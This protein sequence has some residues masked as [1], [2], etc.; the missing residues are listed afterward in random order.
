MFGSYVLSQPN[1][2]DGTDVS[3]QAPFGYVTPPIESLRFAQEEVDNY[4]NKL[5][6][7]L[8]VNIV[9]NVT[10]QSAESKSYYIQQKVS[11]NTYI[12]ES[13]IRLTIDI[14]SYIEMLLQNRNTHT[15]TVDK[16]KTWDIK[17]QND[18]LQELSDAKAENAP[19]NVILELTLE[20]LRK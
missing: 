20:L 15:I 14:F 8:C 10:N 9:Q 1:R 2:L 5:A 16:P 6:Q 18:I 4:Y 19:Y 12:I 13:I 17:S 11:L 7:E 3:L